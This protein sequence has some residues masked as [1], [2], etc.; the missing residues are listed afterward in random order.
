MIIEF[1]RWC[2][3]LPTSLSKRDI[4]FHPKNIRWVLLIIT[5]TQGNKIFVTIS[6]NY[7]DNIS[8]TKMLYWSPISFFFSGD[9]S[10]I[11]M[12][13]WNMGILARWWL[14]YTRKFWKSTTR[15]YMT[16]QP[17]NTKS[18]VKGRVFRLF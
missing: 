14:V 4:I 6:I 13:F 3:F 15:L 16:S 8:R 9:I 1:N 11:W 7:F 18:S 17:M 2:L 5:W 10:P 12:L